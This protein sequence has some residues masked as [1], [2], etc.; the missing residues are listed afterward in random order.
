MHQT[1]KYNPFISLLILF[2]AAAGLLAFRLPDNAFIQMLISRLSKYQEYYRP[3]KIYLLTDRPY[4]TSGET[5][6]LKAFQVDAREHI[7]HSRSRVVYV[8]LLNSSQ[9]LVTNRKLRV[10]NNAAAGDIELPADLP[11]GTYTLRAYTKWMLN[12]EA[13]FIFTK[14]IQIYQPDG[15]TIE[16]TSGMFPPADLQF[17]P[18]SG[19]LVNGLASTVAFKAV[20]KLGKGVDVQGIITSNHRDTVTTFQSYHLGMGVF[21]LQPMA[22]NIYTATLVTSVGDTLRYPLP[23]ASAEGWVMS[24]DNTSP[25]EIKVQLQATANSAGQASII[26]QV[27]GTILFSA[28]ANIPGAVL[29]IPKNTLPEGIVH[30][31]AFDG[32]G[33]ARCE[34]LTFVKHNQHLSIQASSGKKTYQPREQVTVDITVQDKAGKPVAASLAM[35]VTDAGQVAT[36]EYKQDILSYLLLTSDLKGYVEQP[37]FYFS[38]DARAGKALDY[39]L[40]TQGW[41]RF[42][43]RSILQNSFPELRYDME[44]GLSLSGQLLNPA[45]KA[46]VP[47]QL[48]TLSV[49]GGHPAFYQEYTDTEGFFDFVDFTYFHDKD[50]FLRAVNQ[51]DMVIRV[52]TSLTLPWPLIQAPAYAEDKVRTFINKSSIRKKIAA[53][54]ATDEESEEWQI[55]ENGAKAIRPTVADVPAD[56]LIEPDNYNPFSSMPETLKEIVPGLIIKDKKGIYSLRVLDI[57]RKLYFKEEPVYFIDGLLFTDNDIFLKLDPSTV[58]SIEVYGRP[59]K[60][61]RFGNFGRHGV[62]AAYTR[63]GDFYPADYPGLLKVPFRGL[64]QTREFYTPVYDT[65]NPAPQNPDLRPLIYWNPTVT[66]DANGKAQVIFH[67]TDNI[68]PYEIHIEGISATGLPGATSSRYDVQLPMQSKK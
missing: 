35:A 20:N 32:M 29:S 1:K 12:Q 18:E 48:I 44:N 53:A 28:T 50:I 10:E 41:R 5:I 68:G 15:A 39:L 16:N 11:T 62:I 23:A 57:Q 67:N 6:W 51:P 34:R 61:A 21:R 45:T 17:F 56:H 26:A 54:F 52:D 43:W 9:K 24:I 47:N 64:Y 8:E 66:T 59:E 27:R 38:A 2:V 31:T 13:D 40:M 7:P 60:L 36:P 33:N 30:I 55:T 63:N 25:A 14:A 42:T 46:P 58:Q 3:D 19:Q 4:Y 49:P 37:G 65:K 22:G